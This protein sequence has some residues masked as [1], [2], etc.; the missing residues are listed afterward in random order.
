MRIFLESRQ[1]NHI[2]MAYKQLVF[3]LIFICSDIMRA[4]A[5][6]VAISPRN[7]TIRYESLTA[8]FGSSI[9]PSGLEG[10]LVIAN[11]IEACGTINPPPNFPQNETVPYNFFALIQRG[12][13]DFD[14]KVYIAQQ[15][16]YVGA[17]VYN[18]E[19]NTLTTMS[20]SQFA[21]SI[22]IPSVFVG[23]DSGIALKTMNYTTG[24]TVV[25]T[26]DFAFPYHLYLIP[27]ASIVGICFLAMLFFMIAKY[28]RDRRRQRKA[29][30]SR[31]HLRKLPTKKFK[32]GDEYDVCAICLDDYVEGAKLR[33]LPC[34]HAFHCKCV[35]P[36]LTN[37]RRTCPICKRKVVPPGMDDSDEE[38]DSD[39]GDAPNENTPLLAG[40][41]TDNT[42]DRGAVGGVGEISTPPPSPAPSSNDDE[43]DHDTPIVPLISV[44]SDST[45]AGSYPME[46]ASSS[47]QAAPHGLPSV[48]VHSENEMM[49][50]GSRDV[51][52]K[53]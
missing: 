45:S 30:L 12:N 4:A 32:K 7:L 25:L 13:C 41:E 50:P 1:P 14:E 31:D 20:G 21:R 2:K 36:W 17:I 49:Q 42:S 28:V 46:E 22:I 18:N 43:N 23:R 33:I 19:G 35:D 51:T 3:A 47:V 9:K 34:N 26:P 24:F 37:N 27:F 39:A 40:M 15:H 6:V 29:R 44:E 16:G 52:P 53:V 8:A 38:S 10:L 11:P 5:D 48:T